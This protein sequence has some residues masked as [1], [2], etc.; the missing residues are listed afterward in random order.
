MSYFLLSAQLHSFC[1]S[2]QNCPARNVKSFDLIFLILL[3]INLLITFSHSFKVFSSWL[4]IT[5]S[6]ATPVVFSDDFIIS[7]MVLRIPLAFISLTSTSLN[8]CPCT[9]LTHFH[10][11]TLHLVSNS[12]SNP[13]I[14]PVLTIPLSDSQL[15]SF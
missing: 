1:F 12:Y 9:Y 11:H 7:K 6:S 14:I 2:S 4:T 5:P 8:I 10:G 3:L 15:F 13:L